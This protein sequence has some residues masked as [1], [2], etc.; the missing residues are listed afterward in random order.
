[1]GD[2]VS[3]EQD[4]AP[5]FLEEPENLYY[6]VKGKPVTITCRA[7]PAFQIHFRCVGQWVR[8]EHVILL[9]KSD[10]DTGQ[11]YLETSLD[12]TK[13]EVEEYYQSYD[14][15]DDYWCE[16]LAMNRGPNQPTPI[17]VTSK[18]GIIQVACKCRAMSVCCQ[19]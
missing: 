17:T 16:C 15:P 1:M 5:K 3:S 19:S 9:E 8:P 14:A 12:V 11:L 18:K 4:A 7:A 10:P 13:E 6:I 2:S